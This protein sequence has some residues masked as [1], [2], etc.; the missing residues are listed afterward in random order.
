MSVLKTCP[1]CGS[2][3][4]SLRGSENVMNAGPFWYV[5]CENC[6]VA[7]SGDPDKNKAIAEWNMR[8]GDQDE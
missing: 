5:I 1:F 8:V 2:K 4:I 7:T 6:R 3:R